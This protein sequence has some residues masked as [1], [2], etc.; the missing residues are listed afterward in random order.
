MCCVVYLCVLICIYKVEKGGE[1]MEFYTMKQIA[2]MMNVHPNT[3]QKWV[4][5]GKLQ[6]YKIGQSVRIRK[7]D[8]ESFLSEY[9]KGENE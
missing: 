1:Q 8:L 5:A 3:V 2:E 9:K 4:S 6:H 7:E